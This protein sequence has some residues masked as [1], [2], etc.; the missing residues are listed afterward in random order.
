[1]ASRG[2]PKGTGI[3]QSRLF[4]KALVKIIRQCGGVTNAQ[5][6]LLTTGVSIDGKR[7]KKV[8]VSFPTLLKIAADANLKFQRGRPKLEAV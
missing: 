5:R 6:H 3:F 1:M 7:K 2:R 4:K 8:A